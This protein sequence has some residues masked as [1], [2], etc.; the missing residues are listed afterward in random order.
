M[1]VVFQMLMSITVL[2]IS[3]IPK[4]LSSMDQQD[5]YMDHDVI[6]AKDIKIKDVHLQF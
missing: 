1:N 3:E 5:R 2:G 6:Q 4:N